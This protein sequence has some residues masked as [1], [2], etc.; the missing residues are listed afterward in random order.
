MRVTKSLRAV[1]KRFLGVVYLVLFLAVGARC[2]NAQ[3]FNDCLSET[4]SFV[5]RLDGSILAVGDAIWKVQG[6][7]GRCSPPRFNTPESIEACQAELTAIEQR[8]EYVSIVALPGMHL[9]AFQTNGE[10]S[11]MI[12][13]AETNNV[14]FR[15]DPV[16][17]DV[18]TSLTYHFMAIWFAHRPTLDNWRGNVEFYLDSAVQQAHSPAM[19]LVGAPI[20]VR[21]ARSAVRIA[22]FNPPARA[23]QRFT[24]CHQKSSAQVETLA[25]GQ[26]GIVR[27]M[28]RAGGADGPVPFGPRGAGGAYLQ[29]PPYNSDSYKNYEFLEGPFAVELTRSEYK[30]ELSKFPRALQTRIDSGTYQSSST[31]GLVY[32]TIPISV[33]KPFVGIERVE[34]GGV[35]V[36]VPF[37]MPAGWSICANQ[38]GHGGDIENASEEELDRM[39]YIGSDGHGGKCVYIPLALPW[40]YKNGSADPFICTTMPHV[41]NERRP[42]SFHG[43]HNLVYSANTPPTP[44][45]IGKPTPL[46]EQFLIMHSPGRPGGNG[47]VELIFRFTDRYSNPNPTKPACFVFYSGPGAWFPIRPTP[48]GCNTETGGPPIG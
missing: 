6:L 2:A 21:A 8:L 24:S 18:L 5:T 45:S 46:N 27:Q 28:L 25:A 35:P 10:L 33:E 34:I 31:V 42:Y 38:R 23:F 22:L 32:E 12:D 44:E 40:G 7:R 26:W 37:I 4:E 11:T 29:L 1:P 41:V 47:F 36:P 20:P 13:E 15:A 3:T 48:P 43:C 9:S 16:S 30:F 39:V 19:E 17:F 14:G